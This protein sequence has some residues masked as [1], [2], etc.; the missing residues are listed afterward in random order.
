MLSHLGVAPASSFDCETVCTPKLAAPGPAAA[1][2]P[3]VYDLASS[4]DDDGDGAPKRP[5]VSEELDDRAERANLPR[6]FFC[7]ISQS[8]MK[9]PVLAADGHTYE[10]DAIEQWFARKDTSPMT[11]EPLAHK[12]L[13]PNIAIRSAIFELLARS[14]T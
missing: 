6:T 10:R 12:H 1:A 11:N 4:S 7:A 2:A 13:T 3:F 14:G 9:D 8:V 5:R